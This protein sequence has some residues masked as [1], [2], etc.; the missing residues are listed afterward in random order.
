[1]ISFVRASEDTFNTVVLDAL[2]NKRVG[3]PLGEPTLQGPVLPRRPAMRRPAPTRPRYI[4]VLG[5]TNERLQ[6]G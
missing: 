6:T 2:E 5:S 1:M 3:R 4:W